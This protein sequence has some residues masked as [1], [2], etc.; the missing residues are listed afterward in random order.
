[1]YMGILMIVVLLQLQMQ[2][3]LP[4]GMGNISEQAILPEQIAHFI[5]GTS[6]STSATVKPVSQTQAPLA[7]LALS[8]QQLAIATAAST[9]TSANWDP[10][11]NPLG[12]PPGQAVNLPSL[13]SAT[14]D[15]NRVSKNNNYGGK[16]D[17]KHLGGFT[18]FDISGIS[19][20][21]WKHM[22][23]DYGVKS[24]LDVGCGRGV[25]TSWFAKHGLAALCVEGSSDAYQRT[26]LSNP[27]QQ[28]VQHDFSRGPWWPANTYD[29]VWAVE[30]LEHV[31]LQYHYNYIT[32]FRKAALVLVSTSR[33]GGWHHVEVHTD[34]WWIRKY[35]SYGFKYDPIL[36]DQV[37][38]WAKEESRNETAIAP[39]G[40][41]YNAQHVW[42]TMKVFVNPVVAAL[43]QH[44]HLFPEFGCF[45][46]RGNGQIVHRECGTGKE[47]AL[48]TPLDRSLYPLALT[49]EMD[50]EWE[51]L[52]RKDLASSSGGAATT[53]TTT[54]ITSPTTPTT[55][56]PLRTSST[57]VRN[58]PV[59]GGPSHT[60]TR[61]TPAISATKNTPKK[62]I[63][64]KTPV[65][66]GGT[67]TAPPDTDPTAQVVIDNET[68]QEWREGY[69]QYPR[70]ISMTNFTTNDPTQKIPI[71]PV[72]LWPYLEFGIGNAEAQHIEENGVNESSFLELARDMNNFDPNVV[73]VGDTGYA[74]GWNL[75]C[76][77]YLQRIQAAKKQRKA[78]GLPLSWPIYI[79]DFTD[80]VT[81]Q[82]CKNI[83][84]D[85]GK[86]YVLYSQRSV[87][88]KRH[89]DFKKNWIDVGFKIPMAHEDTTYR[90][91]PL[92]VRTDTIEALQEVLKERNLNLA[93]PLEEMERPVDVVHFWPSDWT[94]V[95]NVS[96]VQRTQ[97]S[98]IVA[99][100]AKQENLN[101]F[102]GLA[103][104]A[105][106]TG[107]R[108]VKS[109]YIEAMLNAKI[110]VVT[111]R[112]DWED[113]YRL[114]EAMISGALVLT[115]RM[116]G[117]PQGLIDGTSIIEF[118]SEADLKEKILY[119]LAQPLER[120]EIA[121][122][123]REV[124][125]TRHRTWHRIEEV[126]FG[127]ITSTCSP[128]KPDSPC[129]WIVHA[130]EARR[131]RRR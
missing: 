44:A 64:G 109:E 123:G 99:E 130:N 124:A 23:T 105:V 113:H 90:H 61:T 68:V 128:D 80:G 103:G 87:A 2:T 129:P 121:R 27:D 78:L 71:V 79:V 81:R 21:V 69:K 70:P 47:G 82:R 107:R 76:G 60:A 112:D 59:K 91:S 67:D 114:F 24:V 122:R 14:A 92:V 41:R 66:G 58:E 108:G 36:T 117:M 104:S 65:K 30:F 16:G 83:E 126:I 43:P 84:R 3:Q 28:M 54:T 11:L 10:Q 94:G 5:S 97:V 63:A 8:Q 73:W 127:G 9:A 119:Y 101:A 20:A 106:K 93:S 131:R 29:A 96:S 98:I 4:A 46:G 88:R 38:T 42:L 120:K 13:P 15:T 52:I 72:V 34:E 31:N 110:L 55:T 50:S 37:R 74:Y 39:N 22:V 32:A 100:L 18:Q 85:I 118:G 62:V 116:L 1:M 6:T 33:W 48:E 35:E 49:P 45:G 25:S 57:L 19:P 95:S 7:G 111:Q 26:L 56:T 102:V 40:E 75:W 115:D 86:E 12:I 89:W 17:G 125:M 51:N 53:T 77:E